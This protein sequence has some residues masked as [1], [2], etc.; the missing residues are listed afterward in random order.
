MFDKIKKGIRKMIDEATAEMPT[1][2]IMPA[3]EAVDTVNEQIQDNAEAVNVPSEFGQAVPSSKV[4]RVFDVTGREV[5]EYSLEAHGIEFAVLAENF[6][7][8]IGGIVK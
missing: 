7:K 2:E 3:Q 6:A 4:A 8:K 1:D 5:R